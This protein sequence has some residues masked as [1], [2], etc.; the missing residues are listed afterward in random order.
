MNV[1]EWLNSANAD[2]LAVEEEEE[3]EKSQRSSSSMSIKTES[4][5]GQ[6]VNNCKKGAQLLKRETLP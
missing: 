4:S 5:G 1:D 6:Q 3:K 2:M